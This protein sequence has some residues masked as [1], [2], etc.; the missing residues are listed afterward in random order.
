LNVEG[1]FIRTSSTDAFI[2]NINSGNLA[3]GGAAGNIFFGGSFAETNVFLG[4][5]VSISGN[6]TTNGS[7]VQL[8]GNTAT[9]TSANYQIGYRDVPQVSLSGDVTLGLTDGGK[10][11]YRNAGSDVIIT[12]PD[13]ANVA[14]PTGTE[15]QIWQTSTANIDLVRGTGVLLY[16]AGNTTNANKRVT[17]YGQATLIKVASDTWMVT[18][19]NITGL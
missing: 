15:I 6:L 19:T 12:I 3:F 1:G 18:G 16:Q 5:N 7:N 2:F 11:F 14:L 8:S 4:K 10:S 9:V 13:N 17:T